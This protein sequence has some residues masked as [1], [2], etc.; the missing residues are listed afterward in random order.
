MT[1]SNFVTNY[2]S[3][4]LLSLFLA[5]LQSCHLCYRFCDGRQQELDC[6]GRM[7]DPLWGE[8]GIGRLTAFP[9]AV[10]APLHIM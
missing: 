5:I 8:E 3:I 9:L 2:V 4:K 7:V 6:D 10:F 1:Y